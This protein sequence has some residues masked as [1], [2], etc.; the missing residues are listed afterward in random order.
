MPTILEA[1]NLTKKFLHPTEVEVIRNVDLTVEAGETVAIMGASGEG[2][3]TLL[4]ILGTLEDPTS[5]SLLICGKKGS[6]R[7]RNTTIGFVFQSFFLLED[8]TALDNVLMPARIGRRKKQEARAR[9]L[10]DR[11][12]LSHRADFPVKLL[13]GGEKQRVAI[14][15]ALCNDPD[16][17]MADEPSGN[18]DH[19][20]SDKIHSLLIDL[21]KSEGKTLLTVTHDQRL[22]DLCDR[23][24]TLCNGQ[25]TP[26]NRCTG[27]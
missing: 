27:R 24:L 10:L 8:Y 22:A 13:S 14:A 11:V 16:L 21:V 4:H 17:L 26:V 6:P 7:L 9:D 25:L 2:K 23:T 15:R 12:G 19:N 1:K 5:G 3:S 18:L 20:T